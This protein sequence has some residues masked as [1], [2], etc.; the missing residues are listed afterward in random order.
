[1]LTKKHRARVKHRQRVKHRERVRHRK[2]SNKVKILDFCGS[3]GVLYM[4][5]LGTN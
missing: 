4:P 2:N 5:K 1:M 3:K